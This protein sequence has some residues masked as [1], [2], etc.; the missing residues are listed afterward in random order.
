MFSVKYEKGQFFFQSLKGTQTGNAKLT[1]VPKDYN[2]K[3]HV[4]HF[5]RQSLGA[6]P[7]LSPDPLSEPII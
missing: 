7:P 3:P 4:I 6:T 1:Y 2:Y 5:T